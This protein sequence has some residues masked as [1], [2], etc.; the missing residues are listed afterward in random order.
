MMRSQKHLTAVSKSSFVEFAA[1]CGRWLAPGNLRQWLGVALL[2]VLL[3][4]SLNY[5]EIVPLRRL[6]ALLYDFRVRLLARGAVD[7]RIVIIDID[8]RSLAELGRWPWSRLRLAELVDRVF[9]QYGALLLGLDVILAEA[10]ESSGL[11]ALDALARGPLR[12]NAAYQ[13]AFAGIAPGA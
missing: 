9:G 2:G 1:S 13:S 8:E 12:Q 5:L 10:D 6:D 7:E 3:A 11:P 4:H